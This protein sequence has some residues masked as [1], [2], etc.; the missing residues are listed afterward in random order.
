MPDDLLNIL[1]NSNKD[2]DNQ[3]LMD[4]L[5]GKL[6]K[7]EQHEVEKQMAD[8]EMVSDAVEGLKAMKSQQDIQAYVEQLNKDLNRQLQQKKARR[9]QRRI[10]EA[11]YIYV[12]IAIILALIIIAYMIIQQLSSR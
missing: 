2:I 11:P 6:S 10:K 7:Q 8:N 1:S 9:K 12:A 4:Y 5:S 3:K